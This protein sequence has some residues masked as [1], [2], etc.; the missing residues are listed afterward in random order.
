VGLTAAFML[1]ASRYGFKAVD[2]KTWGFEDRVDID[3][4]GLNHRVRARNNPLT[5]HALPGLACGVTACLVLA[6][7]R[8]AA[9]IFQLPDELFCPL[10]RDQLD[11]R[12]VTSITPRV[13]R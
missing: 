13:S 6:T 2:V 9:H 5:I 4:A 12:E 8:G 3:W 11:S 10:R 7:Q 1:S